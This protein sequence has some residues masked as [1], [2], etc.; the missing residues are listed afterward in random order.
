MFL[1]NPGSGNTVRCDVYLAAMQLEVG[2][3]LQTTTSPNGTPLA[4]VFEEDLGRDVEWQARFLI[5]REALRA[6]GRPAPAPSL[7]GTY[8]MLSAAHAAAGAGVWGARRPWQ[9]A[10]RLAWSGGGRRAGRAQSI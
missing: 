7:A 10:R 6:L 8:G 2:R 5:Y 9:Q 1:S 3:W 4:Q